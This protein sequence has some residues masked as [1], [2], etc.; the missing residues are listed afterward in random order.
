MEKKKGAD[1]KITIK[2]EGSEKTVDV[3][4]SDESVN[5]HNFVSMWVEE[6]EYLIPVEDLWY[7]AEVFDRI[8]SRSK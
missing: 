7:V 6:K 2:A 4:F 3:E 8:R 1:M 5:D